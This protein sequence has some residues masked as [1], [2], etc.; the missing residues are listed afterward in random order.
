MLDDNNI[1]EELIEDVQ[2]YI[3]H[4]LL[5]YVSLNINAGKFS[6]A[7]EFASDS[8]TDILSEKKRHVMK[9]PYL[10]YLKQKVKGLF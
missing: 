2:K 1:P 5:V 8:R 9:W 3:A 10:Q 6:T 4:Y 7:H